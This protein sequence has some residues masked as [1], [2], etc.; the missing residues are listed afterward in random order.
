MFLHD[1]L[2]LKSFPLKSDKQVIVQDH[3]VV[4]ISVVVKIQIVIE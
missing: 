3:S 1:L 4:Y 2:T